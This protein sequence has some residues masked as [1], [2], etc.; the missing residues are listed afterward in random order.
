AAALDAGAE[1]VITPRVADSALILGP[2]LHE[3]RWPPDRWDLLAAGSLVGHL[4]ECGA[5]ITGGYFAD[6]GFKD[7]PDPAR[8]SLPIASVAADGRA[9]IEK[10][11]GSGGELSPATCA[12]QL[13]YEVGDPARY[14]LPDV[15]VDLSQVSFRQVDPDRVQVLGARGSPA[16]PRLK[17]LVGM[18][19]GYL[20]EEMLCYAGHNALARAE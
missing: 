7:V 16:P 20:A 13:L 4:I 9:W 6:P 1:V 12:E 17:V 15:T 2:L 5:Q 11:P 14:L 3:Y 19:E 10:L 8:L 18:P